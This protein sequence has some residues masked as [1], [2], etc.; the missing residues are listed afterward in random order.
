M[1]FDRRPGD[2]FAIQDEIA[3]QV[4][5]ALELSLDPEAKERMTGQ[6]TTNLQAYLAFLQGRALLATGNASSK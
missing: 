5:Q 4:T 2:V 6:G 3:V 1:R